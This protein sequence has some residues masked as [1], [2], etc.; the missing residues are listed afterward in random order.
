[1]SDEAPKRLPASVYREGEEPDPRF[2]LAN[3]RTFLAWLRTSLAM[4][5]GA[6]ALEALALPMA[7]GWRVVAAVI[8]LVLG[9]LAAIQA[10]SGW[11]RTEKAMRRGRPLPSPALG[12][13]L[14]GGVVLVAALVA[15]GLFA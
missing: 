2:S 10:W 14:V 1:M 8:F 5:A 12:A 11:K 7:E 15:I 9:T 4:Y 13:V 3:E 6:F